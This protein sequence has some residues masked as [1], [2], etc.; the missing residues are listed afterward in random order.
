MRLMHAYRT[1]N[2]PGKNAQFILMIFVGVTIEHHVV[3]VSFL[4]IIVLS[5]KTAFFQHFN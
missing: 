2:K 1:K 5:F 4:L 3:A